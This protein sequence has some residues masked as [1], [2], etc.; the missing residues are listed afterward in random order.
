VLLKFE[1][2]R[3]AVLDGVAQPVQRADAGVAAPGEHEL[4]RASGTDHLVVHDVRRHPDQREVAAALTDDLL[5]GGDRD[6]VG[7]SLQCDARAVLD[8][9]GDTLR[10]RYPLGHATSLPCGLCLPAANR[11]PMFAMRT[12]CLKYGR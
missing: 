11:L 5:A 12:Q 8:K 7:E 10:E 9:R 4:A 2:H 6:E 3:V 1:R